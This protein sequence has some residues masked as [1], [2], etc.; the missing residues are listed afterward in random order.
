MKTEIKPGVWRFV[1]DEEEFIRHCME[2]PRGYFLN[3]DR[4]ITGDIASVRMLHRAT[5]NGDLCPHFKD[6]RTKSGYAA[7]LTTTGHCKVFS[8]SRESLDAVFRSLGGT[9][10]VSVCADCMK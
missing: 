2:N 7:N 8:M 1:D 10:S 6:R 3:C 9:G 4:A 5:R